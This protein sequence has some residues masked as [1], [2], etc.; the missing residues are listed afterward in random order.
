MTDW[1]HVDVDDSPKDDAFGPHG[2][3]R[4]TAPRPGTP[5]APGEGLDDAANVGL[6]ENVVQGVEVVAHQGV[7]AEVRGIAARRLLKVLERPLLVRSGDGAHGLHGLP[8]MLDT[9]LARD[10]GGHLVGALRHH[11]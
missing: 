3:A 10:D 7:V 5:V 1:S 8:R 11:L 9:R 2:G 6:Q 4:C